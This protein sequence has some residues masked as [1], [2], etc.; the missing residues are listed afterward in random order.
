MRV[1]GMGHIVFALG[2]AGLG[3]LGLATGHF[4]A[5]WQPVPAH[6]PAREVFAYAN[7]VLMLALGVGLLVKRLSG[8]AACILTLYFLVW[9]ILLRGRIVVAA[10]RAVTSWSALGENGTLIV[11]GLMLIA[12]CSA[13][14]LRSLPGFLKG[15]SGERVARIVF[16]FAVFLMS[17]INFAY[18]KANADFPPAWIPHW[19]GWG[20][21]V[22]SGY[23]ATGVSI[24][25]GICPK[26]ATHAVAVMMSLL[27]LLCWVSFVVQTPANR[28]YWTGLLVGFALTGASWLV[29]ESY[30]NSSWFEWRWSRARLRTLNQPGD[31]RER[32]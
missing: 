4:A 16:A 13:Q 2:I 22:G 32:S 11:G 3:V 5:V 31:S 26:V 6:L 1:F 17:L 20:Y 23:V 12:A 14:S 25:S 15:G 10:P 28:T 27:T 8:L 24:L 21:L 9:S 30:R 19:Y 18:P 7:G 29:A